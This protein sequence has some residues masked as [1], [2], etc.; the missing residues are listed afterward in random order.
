MAKSTRIK[1]IA[2]PYDG[3]K[4]SKRALDMAF[5]LATK[6]KAEILLL[7]CIEKINGSWYSHELKPFYIKEAAKQKVKIRKDIE[8]LRETARKKKIRFGAKIFVT[9]SVVEQLIKATNANKVDLIVMGS[10]GRSGLKKLILG[11]VANGV[12]QR[13]RKQVLIAR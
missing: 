3:S 1:K 12:V 10:H 6:Y 9:D 13:S 4:F 5:N 11:S 7:I 2:V 8:N